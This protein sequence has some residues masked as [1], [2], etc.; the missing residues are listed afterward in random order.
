[1]KPGTQCE[2]L[3]NN[4]DVVLQFTVIMDKD[5]VNNEYYMREQSFRSAVACPAP[6]Q[7]QRAAGRVIS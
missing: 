5:S 3:S 7:P 4:I 2:K 1:M 6:A